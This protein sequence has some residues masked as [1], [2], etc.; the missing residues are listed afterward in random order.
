MSTDIIFIK[1]LKIK[2]HLGIYE[3]ERRVLQT[4]VIDLDIHTDIRKAAA[5]DS[6][7]FSINYKMV[8]DRIKQF[9]KDHEAFDI[10]EALAENIAT[11]V[12]SEFP[13][14]SLRLSISK[15]SIFS[16][17]REVGVCIER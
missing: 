7:E 6:V 10:V 1:G 17:I 13:V 9:I 11:L 15:P 3:W 2:A 4:V 14:S 5:V 16:D 12:K 8:V